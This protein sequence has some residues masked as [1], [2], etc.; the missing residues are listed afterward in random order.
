MNTLSWSDLQKYSKD[1]KIKEKLE[2][3]YSRVNTIV[4]II[5]TGKKEAWDFFFKDS[6]YLALRQT[7][8]WSQMVDNI[9]CGALNRRLDAITW[10]NDVKQQIGDIKDLI[11]DIRFSMASVKK[12][13]ELVRSL[14]SPETIIAFI[15]Y[16]IQNDVIWTERI[17]KIIMQESFHNGVDINR[18]HNLL[19]EISK[20]PQI[21]NFR[22]ENATLNFIK[23]KLMSI[24][25]SFQHTNYPHSDKQ[26][27][28]DFVN[29]LST[30]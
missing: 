7:V 30:H 19:S 24:S 6:L 27:V 4:P 16:M 12:A 13:E 10:N 22:Y 8:Q 14:S 17:I 23:Q 28:R 1:P 5:Y 15:N 9:D 25:W 11:N 29:N 20:V 2:E 21:A 3:I 18:K 26:R